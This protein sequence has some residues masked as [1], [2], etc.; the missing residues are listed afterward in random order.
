MLSRN[1]TNAKNPMEDSLI[2][3]ALDTEIIKSKTLDNYSI[4]NAVEKIL[5]KTCIEIKDKFHLKI[6]STT[7]FYIVSCEKLYSK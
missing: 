1:E 3:F 7:H 5:K 6:K 4:E 2:F